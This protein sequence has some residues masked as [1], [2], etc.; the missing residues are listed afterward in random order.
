MSSR[1]AELRVIL[2]QRQH[3]RC[4]YCEFEMARDEDHAARLV[5]VEAPRF[6]LHPRI[7]ARAIDGVQA[8]F[9]HIVPK[10]DGGP[11]S[12]ANGLAACRFC[13]WLRGNEDL[14]THT[15]HIVALVASQ[16]H[17][18]CLFRDKGVWPRYL[19][20]RSSVME[21]AVA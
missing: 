8:S 21:G 15:A 5:L 14:L 12:L 13:N 6:D 17:P 16:R 1:L 2:A 19:Q 4:I 11:D 20:S 7:I 10:F 3:W 9:E 18:R